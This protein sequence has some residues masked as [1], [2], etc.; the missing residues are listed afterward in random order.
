MSN[1][2][3]INIDINSEQ[4]KAFYELFQQYAEQVEEM[5]DDWKRIEAATGRAGGTMADFEKVSDHSREALMSMAI[6]ADAIGKAVAG[7][8]ASH[9]DLLST[10]RE[11]NDQMGKLSAKAQKLNAGMFGGVGSLAGG[12][13]IEAATSLASAIPALGKVVAALGL[14]TLA[15]KKLGDDAVANQRDAR[16]IGL[17]S[18]Q[19]QAFDLDFGRYIDP[20][21]LNRAATGQ[22]DMSKVAYAQMAAQ[23]NGISQV[24]AASPDQLA[25]RMMQHAHDWWKNTPAAMRNQQTLV[26]TGLD[27]FMSFED[28]RRLG[29]MSDNEFSQAKADYAKNAKQ[30]SVSDKSVND[31]YRMSRG[32]DEKTIQAKTALQDDSPKAARDGLHGVSVAADEATKALHSLVNE[33][34]TPKTVIRHGHAISLPGNGAPSTS[35]P[36]TSRWSSLSRGNQASSPIASQ[37]LTDKQKL[38]ASLDVQNKL[39]AGMLDSVWMAETARGKHLHSLAGANGDFQFMP[40][41][42]R[43]YGVDVNDFGSSARGAGRMYHDLAQHY[44]G[45][46][47]K[48]IAAYN[49]G[50]GNVDR[51]VARNGAQWDQHLP[52]ETRGYL[53]KI[54][55][56]LAQRSTVNLKVDVHN[57]TAARVSMQTHAAAAGS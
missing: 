36:T 40:D 10:L 6:Q 41:V 29:A 57:S 27:K 22:S 11:S 54:T 14:A 2:P 19:T 31:W 35:A 32:I 16:G 25:I 23:M 24:Q 3:I 48:A 55:Q 46:I 49:W 15:M 43:Q 28:V 9:K 38:L 37:P 7:A 51:D 50:V 33:I 17:N 56:A 26:G 4:F 20:S 39:P 13:G 8:L 53:N 45:D 30:F 42:A 18:G 5:P 47:R 34:N 52:A 12:N 1:K 44:R 21:I